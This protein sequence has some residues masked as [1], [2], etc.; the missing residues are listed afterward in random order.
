MVVI[1]VVFLAGCQKEEVIISTDTA[2]D[3]GVGDPT[4]R[5]LKSELD[6]MNTLILGTLMLEASGEAVTTEQAADL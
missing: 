1:S 2:V 6:S 4:E 3:A 5:F